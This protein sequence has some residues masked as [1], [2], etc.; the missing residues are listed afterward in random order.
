MLRDFA[1][2][3]LVETRNLRR[4]R[5][6]ISNFG[7]KMFLAG[8]RSHEKKLN[9]SEPKSAYP[10][11]GALTIFPLYFS[12]MS[13]CSSTLYGHSLTRAEASRAQLK[14]SKSK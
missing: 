13:I 7:A 4:H 6:E 8:N 9:H 10:G 12:S 1:E 14:S 2:A 5:S 11:F 3:P